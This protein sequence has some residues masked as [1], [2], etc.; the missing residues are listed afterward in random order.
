MDILEFF[1]NRLKVYIILMLDDYSHFIGRRLIAFGIE[2]QGTFLAQF[3][4][5]DVEKCVEGPEGTLGTIEGIFNGA[6]LLL[7]SVNVFLMLQ[8]NLL[9]CERAFEQADITGNLRDRHRSQLICPA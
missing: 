5:N 6:I 4:C 1:I 2:A 3:L 8:L 7:L 9:N